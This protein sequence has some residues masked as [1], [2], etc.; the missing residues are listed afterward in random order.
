M[1]LVFWIGIIAC[2][3]CIFPLNC[4][5]LWRLR[6]VLH[7]LASNFS[8]NLNQYEWILLA[9]RII[10]S[11]IFDYRL[12]L[13]LGMAIMKGLL[14]YHQFSKQCTL[15]WGRLNQIWRELWY[16]YSCFLVKSK[17]VYFMLL[18]WFGRNPK[19]HP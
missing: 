14:I 4:F 18:Y 12:W 3:N 11:L 9:W 7:S 8:R 1:R 10:A 16:F 15:V 5:N 13:R 6:L 19:Y 17:N 2:K